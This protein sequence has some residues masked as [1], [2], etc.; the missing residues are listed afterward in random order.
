VTRA[1]HAA[2]VKIP[3]YPG[4]E[5]LEA[6]LRPLVE[7]AATKLAGGTVQRLLGFWVLWHAYG[8]LSSLVDR[9]ILSRSGVYKQRNQFRALFGVNVEDWAPELAAAIAASSMRGTL[10]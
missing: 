10:G 3:Q 5:A 1:L 2:A 4:R 6:V 8:D 9:G 7:P